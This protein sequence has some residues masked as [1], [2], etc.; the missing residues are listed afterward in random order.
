[1]AGND[2]FSQY[3]HSPKVFFLPAF[4]FFLLAAA[5]F[6]HSALYL[7]IVA[8]SFLYVIILTIMGMPMQYTWFFIRTLITGKNKA[9]RN[10]DN[11]L[12]F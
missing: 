7:S 5:A 10:K 1:M 4:P 11:L 9:V 6:V 12:N 8:L 3:S 2:H